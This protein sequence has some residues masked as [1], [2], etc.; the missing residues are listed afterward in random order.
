MREA[1]VQ[2]LDESLDRLWLIPRGGIIG[3]ELEG[4]LVLFHA[5]A[6]QYVA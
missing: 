4:T 5:K 6:V 2:P 1:L 3:F